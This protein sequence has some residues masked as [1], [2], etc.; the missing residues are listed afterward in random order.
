MVGT[1]KTGPPVTQSS[2]GLVHR[3]EPKNCGCWVTPV[4]NSSPSNWKLV[5][6]A[7]SD[8]LTVKISEPNSSTCRSP[9]VIGSLRPA[10]PASAPAFPAG[11]SPAA[12]TAPSGRFVPP[13]SE[14]APPRDSP[15]PSPVVALPSG[16]GLESEPPEPPVVPPSF[17]V[18]AAPDLQPDSGLDHQKQHG[19]GPP[20][21]DSLCETSGRPFVFMAAELTPAVGGHELEVFSGRCGR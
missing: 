4:S 17:A 19:G 1:V 15:R 16:P 21:K 18:P 10:G 20:G 2:A 9:R 7:P 13:A 8:G 12:A 5:T 14:P 6:R 11:P 3:V